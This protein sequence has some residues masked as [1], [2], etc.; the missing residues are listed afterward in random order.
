MSTV[1]SSRAT[2]GHIGAEFS[3]NSQ[4][5][6]VLVKGYFKHSEFVLPN[7]C[8]RPEKHLLA[9]AYLSGLTVSVGGARPSRQFLESQWTL[10]LP[11]ACANTQPVV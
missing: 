3:G 8:L 11:P 7:K 4:S 1:A 10:R 9:Q 5:V 6:C 2:T